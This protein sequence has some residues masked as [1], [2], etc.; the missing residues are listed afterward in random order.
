MNQE[1]LAKIIELQEEIEL[2]KLV[3][4]LSE[5]QPW[6][7]LVLL[8]TRRHNKLLSDIAKRSATLD[9]VRYIQGRLKELTMI[10]M[11]PDYIRSD[12]Q[13]RI[14][15]LEDLRTKSKNVDSQPSNGIFNPDPDIEALLR[16]RST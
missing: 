16:E 11:A 12:I 8:M 1:T 7:A 3:L 13:R 2:E 6:Q 4:N 10:L 14:G 9:D 15:A 5:L